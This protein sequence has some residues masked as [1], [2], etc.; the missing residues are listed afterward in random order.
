MTAFQP[1]GANEIGRRAFFGTTLKLGAGSLLF[2]QLSLNSAQD[3]MEVK[4]HKAGI[5]TGMLTELPAV[6]ALVLVDRDGSGLVSTEKR[7]SRFTVGATAIEIANSANGVAVRVSCTTGLLSRVVLRW[8]TSFPADTVYL[9]DQWE[10]AYGDLQWRYLQ[11]ERIMP[12]YFA[13]RHLLSGATFMAGVKTQPS[14]F[15][16]WTIDAVG[17][18]LWLD[19]RNGGGPC[20]PGNREIT[21]ATII[22]LAGEV[23][24]SPFSSLSRFCRMLCPRPRLPNSPICGNNNWYYSYG[25]GFDADTMRRDAMFLAHLASGHVNRPFG[26]IDAGWTPGSVCPGGPWDAGDANRFPDMPG[27]AAEFKRIGIRPGIWI[28]P[29]ALSKVTDSRRLRAG[30]CIDEERPLDLTL[31][32][33]LSLIHDDVARLH[34]WG[35]ELIKHDFSTYDIFGRWGFMMGA[36]LTDSGWNFADPTLTNAEIILR[37]YR[38]LRMAAGDSVLLGCNTIG[39]IGAGIFEV[40][41][42]GSDTSGKTWERTR[43]MGINGLAYR[44]PQNGALFACD[45]D[46]AAHTS[47]TPWE[48]DRQFLDLVARSGTTLFVSVDPRTVTAEQTDCFRDAVQIAL[49]GGIPGGCEPLDWLHTT[50]PREWRFGRDKI[51]YHWEEPAGANPFKV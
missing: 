33:N 24:E 5:R 43:R 41:R 48:F 13:A 8:K 28:R 37:F 50:T 47:Q 38:T 6:P 2:S 31:Q 35:Y 30:P 23:A 18:S 22:W 19:F 26:V 12:W 21:A 40:Q 15:C 45:P 10:R 11:P 29:T 39:H 4:P 14:A 25:R 7:G 32:E 1:T 44:L 17:I 20:R 27:L 46:C 3:I 49:S 42:I 36:E 9:G 51:S 34:S 16:F